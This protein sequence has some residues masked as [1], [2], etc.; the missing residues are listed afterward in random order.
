MKQMTKFIIA[1]FATSALL[2]VAAFAGDAKDTDYVRGVNGNTVGSSE[3]G[4]CWHDGYWTPSS[5]VAPCGPRKEPVAEVTP[6]AAAP[7]VA[8]A[9]SPILLTAPAKTYSK[10]MSFSA[11]AMFA[12][13]KSELKPEGKLMLDD[14]VRQLNNTSYET[15]VATGY[16]DRIGGVQY[17]QTLSLHRANA[18][19]DYLVSRDIPSGRIDAE[20]KGKSQ[21]VTAAGDCTGAKSAKV[22]ACLQPD[23][24]V[25]VEMKGVTT[26]TSSR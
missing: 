13:N 4:Q 2:P 20:G 24:R 21:P 1:A 6:A 12:F 5:S 25:D 11:D 17:N 22:I 26:V 18:V 7:V 15:I 23:R 19:K 3:P 8:V 9:P 16:T 10:S 14:L